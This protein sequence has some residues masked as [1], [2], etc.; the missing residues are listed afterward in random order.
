MM[1]TD[2]QED[3]MVRFTQFIRHGQGQIRKEKQTKPD[4]S[5]GKPVF[6]VSKWL[7]DNDADWAE[8]IGIFVLPNGAT[9]EEGIFHLSPELSRALDTKGWSG[10]DFTA[11]DVSMVILTA[12]ASTWPEMKPK[13]LIRAFAVVSS[14]FGLQ[15]YPQTLGRFAPKRAS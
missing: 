9:R 3:D 8:S 2:E 13:D 1:G 15:N 12:I 7:S 4:A 6:T 5:S 11:Q 14:F 10:K